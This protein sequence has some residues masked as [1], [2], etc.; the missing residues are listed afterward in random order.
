LEGETVNM[1]LSLKSDLA[2]NPDARFLGAPAQELN[3]NHLFRSERNIYNHA[4][5]I[6]S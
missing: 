6:S 2:N 3:C 5:A 1:P 4:P